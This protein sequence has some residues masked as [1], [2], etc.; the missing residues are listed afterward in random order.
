M[1]K[2]STI[3]GIIFIVL[4]LLLIHSGDLTGWAAVASG[5]LLILMRVEFYRITH[6]CKPTSNAARSFHKAAYSHEKIRRYV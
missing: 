2:T 3:G 5:L 4:G 1:T 6:D